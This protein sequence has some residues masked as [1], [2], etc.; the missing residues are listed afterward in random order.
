MKRALQIVLLVLSLVPLYFAITGVWGGAAALN[1]DAV[2][3]ALD[4][5]FR[6]LS[7]FYLVLTFLIWWMIPNIEQHTT[8]VRLI[9]LA[10]FIGGLARAF[11]YMSVGEPQ[12]IQI[13]GMALELGSPVL[14]VWQSRIK[15]T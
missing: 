14:A 5:Q 3:A 6:Y 11:S 4:N 15:S 2:S 12:A 10:L 9:V 13:L 1:G 8:L 7:G